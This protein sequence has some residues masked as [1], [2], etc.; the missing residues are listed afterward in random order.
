MYVFRRQRQVDAS[1][2]SGNAHRVYLKRSPFLGS[3]FR[4]CCFS[5]S[6]SWSFLALIRERAR[7]ITGIA[8]SPMLINI[9]TKPSVT[10]KFTSIRRRKK[11]GGSFSRLTSEQ[12]PWCIL[13]VV[14]VASN[15]SSQAAHTELQCHANST[16]G[17]SLQV[18]GQHRRR[19]R[20]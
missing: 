18:I 7:T 17:L 20:R 10:F 5:T 12:I 11:G 4:P 6:S 13:G 1:G 9:I 16:L 2:P 8:P 19:A 15:H 14:D 3:E